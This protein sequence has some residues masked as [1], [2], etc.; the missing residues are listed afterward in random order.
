MRRRGRHQAKEL[1]PRALATMVRR[2]RSFANSRQVAARLDQSVLL[3]G[4]EV[5]AC[6]RPEVGY[7][8]VERDAFYET[9]DARNVRFTVAGP[10]LW[11][12]S[13]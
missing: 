5:R 1:Q 13:A 7:S 3:D 6:L 12:V 4:D 11:S 2:P 9:L 8:D 10:R